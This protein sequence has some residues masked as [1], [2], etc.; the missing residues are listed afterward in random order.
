MKIRLTYR[1]EAFIEGDD[2]TDIKNKW[3][4]QMP[5]PDDTEDIGFDFVEMVSIE[6]ADTYEDMTNEW[7]GW[8]DE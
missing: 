3:H 1:V 4:K 5:V 7:T 2:M 6:D 8:K